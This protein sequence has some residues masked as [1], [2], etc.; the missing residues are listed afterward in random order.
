MEK[1]ISKI[2]YK[3][4]KSPEFENEEQEKITNKKED[5]EQDNKSKT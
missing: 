2:R 3:L 1:I 4:K 5:K